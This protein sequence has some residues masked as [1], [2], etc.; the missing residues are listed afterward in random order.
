MLTPL[1]T[2][3]SKIYSDLSG[4]KR[5]INN[6]YSQ[7]NRSSPSPSAQA[8]QELLAK[9]EYEAKLFQTLAEN[10]RPRRDIERQDFQLFTDYQAT[11]NRAEGDEFL[12]TVKKICS[13]LT[14]LN[15]A[16]EVK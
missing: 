9:L 14:K 8:Y 6:R 13:H 4:L 16:L 2:Y 7:I 5:K 11:I 1:P 10:N 12:S 3:I 15:S